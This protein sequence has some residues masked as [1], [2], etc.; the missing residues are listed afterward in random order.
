MGG[1]VNGG[2]YGRDVTTADLDQEWLTYDVDFRDIYRDI[3]ENH[4]GNDA[5][6]VF[7]EAQPTSHDLGLV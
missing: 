1:G 6:P 2:V 4:L 7:P 3:I 5:S